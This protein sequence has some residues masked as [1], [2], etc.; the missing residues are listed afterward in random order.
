[1]QALPYHYAKAD[2]GAD[3]LVEICVTGGSGGK[4]FVASAGNRPALMYLAERR[5]DSIVELDE[6][7]AWKILTKWGD[8]ALYEQVRITGD[9]E[10]GRHFLGMTCLMIA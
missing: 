9:P 10:I 6:K 7:I 1:M 3:Y 2:A 5:P 8:A 4:W